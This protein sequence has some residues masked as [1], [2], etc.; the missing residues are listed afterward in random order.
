MRDSLHGKEIV[1]DVQVDRGPR[2]EPGQKGKKEKNM[3]KEKKEKKLW[4]S[5]NFDHFV[6]VGLRE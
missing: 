2:G 4:S 5:H 6:A 3:E 1:A